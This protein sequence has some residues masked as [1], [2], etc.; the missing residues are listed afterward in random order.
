MSP[1]SPTPSN[2][3]VLVG[4]DAK[5]ANGV[6]PGEVGLGG[7]L[8]DKVPWSWSGVGRWVGWAGRWARAARKGRMKLRWLGR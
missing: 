5:M 3:T 8:W 6:G 4:K 7:G 1:T 2:G